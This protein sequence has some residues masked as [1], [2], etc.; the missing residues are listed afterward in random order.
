MKY[1]PNT[2]CMFE[3]LAA[4]P[5]A[6]LLSYGVALAPHVLISVAKIKPMEVPQQV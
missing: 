5:A 1:P 3:L 6:E 4:W 2:M